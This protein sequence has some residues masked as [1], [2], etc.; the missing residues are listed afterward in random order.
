MSL[1][2]GNRITTKDLLINID[3][4]SKMSK[5][6]DRLNYWWAQI[7]SG[8][9]TTQAGLEGLMD[10]STAY[11]INS[12]MHQSDIKFGDA[13]QQIRDGDNNSLGGV[14]ALPSY[15]TRT[16]N[17]T[18]LAKGWIWIPE[19]GD[20]E[21]AV[22]GDDA[23]H[24]K[25]D[26]VLI[27][28][29][30]NGHGFAFQSTRPATG[31][32]TVTL[33][34]GWHLFETQMEENGGGDG[35]AVAWKIPNGSW[36]VIP[37]NYFRPLFSNTGTSSATIGDWERKYDTFRRGSNNFLTFNG[38]SYTMAIDT[39]GFTAGNIWTIEVILRT[40]DN[41]L[42]QRFL[43]PNT[44]G[45]DNFLELTSGQ[46]R[47]YYTETSDVNNRSISGGT[48]VN[49]EWIHI[50][51]TMNISTTELWVNGVSVNTQTE[52]FAIGSWN[53]RIEL[54]QRGNSAQYLDG[55]IALVRM[56]DKVLTDEEIKQNFIAIRGR[57]GL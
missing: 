45:S 14:D 37:E 3:P 55:D 50:I 21:F 19:T 2:H 40:N 22:D 18:W 54:G 30:Y 39:P 16:S 25:I 5:N 28:Y 49:N 51:A 56:Y 15:L 26:D 53:D 7:P 27:A 24:L 13:S 9:P 20:Y 12:G 44:N 4:S 11:T 48:V 52:T 23:L 8:H 10:S 17:Y 41:T 46:V 57:F 43:T 36:E 6:A 33:T 47:F 31:V 35:L 34:K 32:A 1:N 42:D 38:S 29:W